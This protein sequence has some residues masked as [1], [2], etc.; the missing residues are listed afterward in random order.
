MLPGQCSGASD[1]SVHLHRIEDVA[2]GPTMPLCGH[3]FPLQ[4][5][6]EHQQDCTEHGAFQQ[7]MWGEKEIRIGI[8]EQFSNSVYHG[9]Q[10]SYFTS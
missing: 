3:W 2:V 10:L 5:A 9:N 8:M 1:A 7:K 4:Q 6:A